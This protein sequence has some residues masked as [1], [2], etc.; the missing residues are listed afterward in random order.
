[1]KVT[2]KHFPNQHLSVG[3]C[4]C[5]LVLKIMFGQNRIYSTT[6]LTTIHEKRRNKKIFVYS[7]C[8]VW[9][10]C[11]KSLLVVFDC[12]QFWLSIHCKQYENTCRIE[13][14]CIC[15][16]IC[17]WLKRWNVYFPMTLNFTLIFLSFFHFVVVRLLSRDLGNSVLLKL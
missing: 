15:C 11:A 4:V 12:I 7:K 1:M 2:L 16:F 13:W 14:E 6:T 5:V 3:A 8:D 17:F 10:M 9:K